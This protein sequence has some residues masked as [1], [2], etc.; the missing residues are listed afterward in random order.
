[1]KTTKASQ[2]QT[3]KAPKPASGPKATSK[4]SKP[5]KTTTTASTSSTKTA[6]ANAHA[7]AKSTKHSGAATPTTLTASNTSSTT[8]TT[9]NTTSTTGGST[10]TST[11]WQP[12]NAVSKKLASKPNLLSRVQTS[13]PAGT[14]LNAATSGFKN[15]GQFVAA[16]NVSNNLG[17]NFSDLK[18]AMTGTT[19][20]GVSTGQPTASL[21]QAI[22]RF[23]PEANA[24]V[25]ANTAQSLA[26]QEIVA[27][28]R[29]TKKSGSSTV[30]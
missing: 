2:A 3:A 16:V 26:N 18:T 23:R 12:N 5:V 20:A 8:T 19:M 13:L 27:P 6:K 30:S 15:F 22:Q 10:T 29:K 1:M 7:S 17:I 14:D 21:G 9:T 4:P 24:D 25:E 28:V 11:A